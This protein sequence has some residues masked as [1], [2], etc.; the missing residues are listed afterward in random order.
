MEG[1][2]ITRRGDDD[3]TLLDRIGARLFKILEQHKFVYKRK[4][5]IRKLDAV[6]REEAGWPQ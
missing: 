2:R 4:E 5:L 1:I 3:R 6:M